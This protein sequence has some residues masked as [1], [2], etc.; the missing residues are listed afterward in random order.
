MKNYT[1]K[2]KGDKLYL[3]IWL[4]K[5]LKDHHDNVPK[6][7]TFLSPWFLTAEIVQ[8]M[9]IPKSMSGQSS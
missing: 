7:L 2:L 3:K 1:E 5:V 6:I 8:D 9:P 4:Q